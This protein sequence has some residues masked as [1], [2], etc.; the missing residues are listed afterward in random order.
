MDDL[1]VNWDNQVGFF[2]KWNE[3]DWVD[4]IIKIF[5]E[6]VEQ[7]FGVNDLIVFCGYQGLI[8]DFQF[9]VFQGGVKLVFNMYV[10]GCMVV[11]FLV[12]VVIGIVVIFY[13]G[14]YGGIGIVGYF[15]D[16]FVIFR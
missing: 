1:F 13:G 16:C 5:I 8:V 15:I 9:V 11:Y 14:V 12:E 7:G 4:K 6:L 10:F 2:Q 3:S